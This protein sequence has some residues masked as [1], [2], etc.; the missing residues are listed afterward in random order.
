VPDTKVGRFGIVRKSSQI[1]TAGGVLE[2]T[3]VGFHAGNA[4]AKS[5][6]VDFKLW[7]E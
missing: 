3:V 6:G 1:E 7:V 4:R 5:G 2:V